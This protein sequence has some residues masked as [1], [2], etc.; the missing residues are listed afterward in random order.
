MANTPNRWAIR[1]AAE[2]TFYNIVTGDAIVTLQTLKMSEVQTS[3]ETTYARGG[4][5]NAKL[6][7]FTSNREAKVTLQD[8]LFDNLALAMLTGNAVTSGAKTIS[9]F[10]R[11]VLSATKTMTLPAVP[12]KI[13]SVHPL[14]FDGT[15]PLAAITTYTVSAGTVTVTAGVTGDKYVVY[16]EILTAADAKTI[17][18]TSDKFGGTFKLVVDVMVRD[19]YTGQDFFG[20]FIANRAKIEDDFSF[21]FSPDGD[22]AVLDIPL[23]IL[24]NPENTDM[25]ELVIYS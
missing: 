18:V 15:T 4:R 19:A 25:W 11:G 21:N 14:S 3:G 8:A 13:L 2:A 6:V 24:K 5:G 23:E 17:K 7:G 1:E 22:P 12:T 9:K 20:Q 16:Y 10:H